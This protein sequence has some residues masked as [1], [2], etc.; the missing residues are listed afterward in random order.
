MLAS[1]RPVPLHTLAEH[2]RDE[3]WLDMAVVDRRPLQRVQVTNINVMRD[4]DEV[5]VVQVI[6]EE[7]GRTTAEVAFD[8]EDLRWCKP[9]TA[10][11]E[12]IVPLEVVESEPDADTAFAVIRREV[13]SA[14]KFVHVCSE[15]ELLNGSGFSLARQRGIRLLYELT[16]FPTTRLAEEI[17]YKSPGMYPQALSRTT[18]AE[19]VEAIRTMVMLI[20][21]RLGRKPRR[22]EG[23][24]SRAAY[25]G[26]VL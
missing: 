18:R 24:F 12:D 6:Q 21:N 10:R 4:R 14:L 3:T 5:T 23:N 8:A 19:E 11:P 17:G 26:S 15:S 25:G 16:N 20:D 13:I 1:L 2:L 22:Y 7:E 9:T